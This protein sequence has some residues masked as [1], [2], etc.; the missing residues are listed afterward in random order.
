MLQEFGPDIYTVT[1][2]TVSSMKTAISR[3]AGVLLALAVCLGTAGCAP[4]EVT[5]EKDVERNG[6][7]FA[8][9]RE[10]S[11]GTKMGD[12]AAETVIEGWP[13]R[14]GFASFHADWRLDECHLSRDY[15]RNG[16][17]MPAGTRIFPDPRGNPGVV[18]FPRDVDVQGFLVRGTRKG[19]Y[20][21][22]FYPSGKLHWFYPRDPV[23]VGG[24][25]C[26]TSLFE[27]V[28]LH[29]DGGLRQCKLAETA[30]I[31]GAEYRK[32]SVIR[33]DEDGVVIK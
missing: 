27:A 5:A 9:F 14:K 4:W 8:T 12:L 11:D 33:L 25:T 13:C 21:T 7:R 28:Y 24:I 20:M 19:G 26:A 2:P 3:S 23:Q 30:T 22:A 1:W 17:V 10:N 32:G 18:L 15:E 16:I 6:I 31:H 29:R